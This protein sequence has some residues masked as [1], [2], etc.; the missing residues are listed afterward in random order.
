MD[1][2]RPYLIPLPKFEVGVLQSVGESLTTDS[3]ALEYTIA[4]QLVEHQCGIDVTLIPA[5]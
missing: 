4:G 2:S 1:H 3:D 5:N